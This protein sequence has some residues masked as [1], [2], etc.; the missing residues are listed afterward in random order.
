MTY[1]SKTIRGNNGGHVHKKISISSSKRLRFG[2]FLISFLRISM[3]AIYFFGI[4]QISNDS[5]FS[6]DNE[7]H[8]DG[9]DQGNGGHGKHEAML[10]LRPLAD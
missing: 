3:T 10:P 4:L 6:Y 1:Y 5:H 9:W 2:A 8:D 7:E